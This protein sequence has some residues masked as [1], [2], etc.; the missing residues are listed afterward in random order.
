MEGKRWS[1]TK[2]SHYLLWK[3]PHNSCEINE[4]ERI[5]WKYVSTVYNGDVSIYINV[6]ADNMVPNVYYYHAKWPGYRKLL[7]AVESKYER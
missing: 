2:F 4:C 6:S 7:F 3:Y 1:Y 5:D